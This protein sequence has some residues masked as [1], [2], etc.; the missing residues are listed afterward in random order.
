MGGKPKTIYSDN[1][2]AFMS[3]E[4]H[5][6]TPCLIEV[7]CMCGVQTVHDDHSIAQGVQAKRQD[8]KLPPVKLMKRAVRC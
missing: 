2:G 7:S 3:N 5:S 6:N 1:E 8:P 4:I